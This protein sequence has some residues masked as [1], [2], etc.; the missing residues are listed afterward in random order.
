[1]A[2]ANASE[3]THLLARAAQ[4][5]Q[6]AR[7][8]TRHR[9]HAFAVSRAYYAMFYVA[10][11]LLLTK[12]LT[13]SKHSAVIAAFGQHFAKTNLRHRQ[14][15][16]YLIEAFEQRQIADYAVEEELGAA[17]A[18]RQLVRAAAFLRA[19]RAWL[20]RHPADV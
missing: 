2:N 18:R 19:V 13:V 20:K 16:R 6:A 5:L 15:H 7:M 14:F 9:H 3:V 8:L 10:E 11:A 4:S 12:H 1:M 17:D